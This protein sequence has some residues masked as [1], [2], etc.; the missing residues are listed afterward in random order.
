MGYH[1]DG[2]EFGMLSTI[3]G[4]IGITHGIYGKGW[5][6]SFIHRT[7]MIAFSV[8]I[9][10]IGICMPLVV[11]PLRRKLGFPTNQYD[12]EDPNTV[13]PKLIE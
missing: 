5:F 2:H 4:A 10:G 1:I 9:A 11:V 12:H 7:P 6:K 3:G 8:T 13:C